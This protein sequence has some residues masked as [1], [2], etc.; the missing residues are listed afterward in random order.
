VN[1]VTDFPDARYAVIKGLQTEPGREQIVLA[2]PSE[3]SLRELF[4]ASSIVAL[5]FATRYEAAVAG[6]QSFP[7]VVPDQQTSKAL[8]GAEINKPRDERNSAHPRKE[9][10]FILRRL[11]RFLVACCSDFANFAMVIYSSSNTVSTAIRM[12]LGSSL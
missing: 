2:Y 5:G 4:A 8:A 6:R 9:T 11:G 10:A 7:D 12:A 1:A 3:K